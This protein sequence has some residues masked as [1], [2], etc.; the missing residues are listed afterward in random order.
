MNDMAALRSLLS[1]GAN[2]N[3]ADA[4]IGECLALVKAFLEIR[5][6]VLRREIIQRAENAA[7]ASKRR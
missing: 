6:P 3:V 4:P 1:S 7:R 2:D 5:D